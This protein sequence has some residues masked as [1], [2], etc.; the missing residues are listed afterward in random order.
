MWLVAEGHGGVQVAM[1]PKPGG[2]TQPSRSSSGGGGGGESASQKRPWLQ[3]V[4]LL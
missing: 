1:V 3:Q 2:P 4:L